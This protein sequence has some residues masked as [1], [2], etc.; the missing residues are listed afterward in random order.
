MCAHQV[1]MGCLFVAAVVGGAPVT[2]ARFIGLGEDVVGIGGVSPNGQ[3]IVGSRELPP[4]QQPVCPP[5][6]LCALRTAPF[7]W[8]LAG[9]LQYID[10]AGFQVGLAISDDGKPVTGKWRDFDAPEQG[11]FLWSEAE[12]VL[13]LGELPGVDDRGHGTDIS[14]DGTVVVGGVGDDLFG[15]SYGSHPQAFRWSADQRLQGL[16]D[17]DGGAFRSFATAVSPDGR[18]VVGEATSSGD[19]GGQAFRWTEETGMV[20]LG[21]VE[22]R[23]QSTAR[24]VSSDGSVVVGYG[25]G[26]L[27]D[28]RAFRWTPETGME[29]LGF[30][31]AE[32]VTGDGRTIVG[33]SQGA[34]SSVAVIWN[35]G[36][37]VRNLREFLINE[38]GLADA[39]A[40]WK[41][42]SALDISSDGRTITGFGENPLGSLEAWVFTTGLQPLVGDF[43]GDAIVDASDYVVWR[44]TLGHTGAGLA[45]DGNGNGEIDAGDYEVWRSHFGQATARSS[46]A[47]RLANASSVVPEPDASLLLAAAFFAVAGTARRGLRFA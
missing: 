13:D 11:P 26:L 7:R 32:A 30:Q 29:H 1:L 42:T 23:I 18:V 31:I 21:F 46:D 20:G 47:I 34:A 40:G 19:V 12:G 3:W 8:S 17:L 43:N 45:A 28:P 15:T 44:G 35:A 14:A 37:G 41:L 33:S 10:Q 4:E 39:L 38:H 36:E 2:A 25:Y 6:A 9:E 24:D 22:D 5:N 27:A 16:G